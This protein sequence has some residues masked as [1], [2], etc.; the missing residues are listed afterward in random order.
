VGWSSVR[1]RLRL[2]DERGFTM[3][4]ALGALMVASGMS[5]AAFAAAGG[6]LRLGRY[7][8]DKKEAYAAAEAGL[9]YYLHQLDKDNDFWRLC[10][11][12]RA[13]G[14]PVNQAWDGRS[15]AGDPRLWAKVPRFGRDARDFTEPAPEYTIELLP[16]PGYDSCQAGVDASMIDPES[17]GFRIRATGRVPKA[18][19]AK[20]AARSI[21]ATLRRESFL[22]YVYFTD[23]ETGDPIDWYY[24]RYGSDAVAW[25]SKHCEDWWRDGR[26]NV[27]VY[28]DPQTGQKIGCAEI[29]FTGGDKVNGP[30]HTNDEPLV[31]KSPTFGGLEEDEIEASGPC[32]RRL[33]GSLIKPKAPY[34]AGVTCPNP[35]PN[36]VGK[37]LPNSE[38]LAMPPSNTELGTVVEPAYRFRGKTQIKLTGNTV[39]VNG[40]RAN[41]TAVNGTV[42]LPQNGVIYVENGACAGYDPLDPDTFADTKARNCGNAYVEGDYGKDLT[43]GAQNDIVVTDDVKRT[44]NTVL[45]LIADN[46]VRVEHRVTRDQDDPEDC[47]EVS[48]SKDRQVEAAILSLRHSFVIDNWYCGRPKGTLTV[49]GAIAQK[50]RGFVGRFDEDGDPTSGYTKNYIYDDR[51]RFRTPPYFVDPVESP[52]ELVRQGEQVPP[53]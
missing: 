44:G 30:F 3:V 50:F 34:P 45:G 29:Y 2:R 25:A 9:H 33:E 38:I 22:D 6:D 41:G 21:V 20:V 47:K 11:T 8:Q 5:V 12:P 15:P 51:L 24:A 52:W 28:K 18:G 4:A 1:R 49:D 13:Q 53:R 46:L 39:Q 40:R 35:P 48:T 36:F 43:I 14:K 23:Y 10:D 27:A 17:G 26:G 19:E 31:F 7:D 16:A 37:W 42:P 32:W